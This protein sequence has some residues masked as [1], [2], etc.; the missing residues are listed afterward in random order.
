MYDPQ[1]LH[2]IAANISQPVPQGSSLN[3]LRAFARKQS[4]YFRYGTSTPAETVFAKIQETWDWVKDQL[5][6]GAE[7]AKKKAGDANSKIRDEL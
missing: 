5:N 1:L 3:E 6:I 7:E 2:S 4:T